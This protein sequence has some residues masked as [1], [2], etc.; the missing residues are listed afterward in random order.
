[1]K[2]GMLNFVCTCAGVSLKCSA[3]GAALSPLGLITV[4]AIAIPIVSSVIQNKELIGR[5][6]ALKASK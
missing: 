4:A 1:M 6:K 2:A 5:V 3:A